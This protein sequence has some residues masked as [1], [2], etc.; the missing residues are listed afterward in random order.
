MAATVIN[1][2][3]INLLSLNVR[4]LGNCV[5]KNSLFHWLKKHHRIEDKIVF[6]Q[7]THVTKDKE[8]K[9]DKAWGGEKLFANGTSRKRGVVT[10]L[11]KDMD[12]KLLDEKKDPDGRY[13]A[14]KI[15]IDGNKYG[16]I[17]GYAPTADFLAEQIV[18]LSKISAILEEY[19][20]SQIIFGGDI[21]EGLTKLDKFGSCRDK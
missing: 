11:P 17:N 1:K 3:P 13:V 9:W 15:E 18:W 2:V 16:L 8:S 6:L 12:Y 4:G 21:N 14:L 7:E 20:D 10:L 19:G 5:K